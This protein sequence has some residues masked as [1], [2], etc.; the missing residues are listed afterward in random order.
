MKEKIKI[1][2]G[3]QYLR[4]IASLLVVFYHG[5]EVSGR[6]EL[7]YNLGAYLFKAGDVGVDI[8]FILSGFVM[9]AS[10]ERRKMTSMGSLFQFLKNRWFRVA[11][12][13]Y[14]WTLFF[15]L[16]YTHATGIKEL[17]S[18]FLFIPGI[19]RFPP[20]PVGW[21]LNFEMYFYL[22]IALFAFIRKSKALLFFLL[23]CP[24]LGLLLETGIDYLD[25]IMLSKHL[26]EFLIGMLIYKY[27]EKIKITRNT[28]ILIFVVT[29]VVFII[30]Y[31]FNF[32]EDFYIKMINS[33]LLLIT[34]VKLEEHVKLN[35]GPLAF[36]GKISYS[37]YLCH[38]PVLMFLPLVMSYKF[39]IAEEFIRSGFMDIILIGFVIM[40]SLLSY[41]LIEKPFIW[42]GKKTKKE[43]KQ[44]FNHITGNKLKFTGLLK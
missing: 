4:G 25:K 42:L 17:I 36:L 20:L 22:I 15:I 44:E 7:P 29:C 32:V 39:N 10:I 41:L 23:V 24:F 37:V 40:V 34:L 21:T 2:E 9:I 5:Y 38:I 19:D 13:Y 27:H 18:A 12:A 26:W 8:F 30:F 31:I 16:F 3:L 43:K 6:F 14:F 1:F 11:P 33:A 28:A 35:S